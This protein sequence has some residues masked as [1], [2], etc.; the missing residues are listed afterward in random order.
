M[1]I[2]KIDTVGSFFVGQGDIIVF[3]KPANYATTALSDLAN[4]K[5]LGDIHLDS[6]NFT[7]DDP[8]LTP[9]KNEQGLAYYTTVENGTFGFEFFVPSTSSAMLTALMNAEVVT[10]TFT[11]G[12]AFAVGST[13]TGA[14]HKSTIVENPIMIVN[15]TKNRAL[16]VP[17]AKIVSSLAMQDRVAGI[18]VRV[19]AENIDTEDLKTVMFVDGA[20][21]YA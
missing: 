4:P 2:G 15:E 13:I 16:V 14:M 6:T 1:A 9:L 8:T 3:D 17:K 11:T 21:A 19:N 12:D 10:D 7:G 5:S 20:I 18:M